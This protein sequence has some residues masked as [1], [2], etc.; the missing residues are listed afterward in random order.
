[1]VSGTEISRPY[2][3]VVK[4]GKVIFGASEKVD[5]ELEFATIIGKS[6]LLGNPI[7]IN[8]A[9]DYIFGFVSLQALVLL[10][11]YLLGIVFALII[12]W[13]MKKTLQ[14][15]GLGHFILELPAYQRPVFKNL[16]LTVFEKVKVF[17]VDAGKI[18][19]C[20][21]ITDSGSIPAKGSPRPLA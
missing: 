20:I 6:N 13:F 4:D 1:M 18:I 3:Q 2:G 19:F 10:S 14:E 21:S 12:S 7:E 11:M 5:F 16:G 9:E 8:D 17:V 15:K